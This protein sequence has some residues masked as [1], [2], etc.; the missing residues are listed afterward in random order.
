MKKQ[1]LILC[2]LLV[3]YVPQQE[4]YRRAFNLLEKE[5][6]NL[7]IR[8]HIFGILLAAVLILRTQP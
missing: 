7:I 2:Q 1:Y 3:K 8:A 6:K 5:V 4:V